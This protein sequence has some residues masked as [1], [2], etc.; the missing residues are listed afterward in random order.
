MLGRLEEAAASRGVVVDAIEGRW[1]DVAASA[2]LVDLVVCHHVVYNA[3][4]IG[5]FVDALTAHARRAVVV[6][7]TAVHPQSPWNEAWRHFWAVDRPVGPTADDLVAVLRDR[8]RAPELW[9]HRRPPDD[10]PPFT[11]DERAVR[12][13]RRRLCL[14]PDRADEVADFLR[15][16]P[17]TWPDEVVTLRW[18]PPRVSL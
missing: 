4:D 13:M 10:S 5:P 15:D 1:P 16:H 2:P 14:R 9:R 17:L 6:E 18:R 3:P 11:D 8:G 12:S 7:V